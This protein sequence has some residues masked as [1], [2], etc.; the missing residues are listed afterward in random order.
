[1][2]D[3]RVLPQSKG[4]LINQTE[5]TFGTAMGLCAGFLTKKLGKL[6]A[7]F[8]GAGFLFLQYMASKGYV[9]VN[10]KKLDRTYRQRLDADHDGKVT[11]RDI[12]THWDQFSKLLT[13]NLQFKSTFLVGFAIGFRYG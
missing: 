8:I 7:G 6:M 9:N 1:M 2:H 10:W 12:S 11:S 13:N 5:L 3:T 4:P